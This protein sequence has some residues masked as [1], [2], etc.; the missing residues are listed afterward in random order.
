MLLPEQLVLHHLAKKTYINKLQWS[1]YPMYKY[2]FPLSA[3]R[4]FYGGKTFK[5]D[6]YRNHIKLLWRMRAEMQLPNI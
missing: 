5:W 2:N 4:R 1:T 3:A 6:K